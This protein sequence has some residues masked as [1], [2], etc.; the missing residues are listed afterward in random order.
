MTGG[1]RHCVRRGAGA[2]LERSSNGS[3]ALPIVGQAL[4]LPSEGVLPR[5]A[6]HP[7]YK[8]EADPFELRSTLTKPVTL[9]PGTTL[10]DN[11]PNP[12]RTKLSSEELLQM[13]GRVRI[14]L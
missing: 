2:S 14:G 8:P 12:A 7:P 4:R 10:P 6:G 13:Q 1:Q 9:G 3:A 11:L 5:Q